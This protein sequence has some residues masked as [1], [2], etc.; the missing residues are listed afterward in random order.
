MY[1]LSVSGKP[2]DRVGRKNLYFCK[3]AFFFA[4]YKIRAQELS[5]DVSFVIIGPIR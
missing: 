2:L 4:D 5:N 1:N 3:V